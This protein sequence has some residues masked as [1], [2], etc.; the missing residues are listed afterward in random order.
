[1]DDTRKFGLVAI[2]IGGLICAWQMYEVNH[3]NHFTLWVIGFI[4]LPVI[5][6]GILF[7]LGGLIALIKGD[8]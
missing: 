8:R 4:P 5:V 3:T 6:L 7:V 1:M 2:V